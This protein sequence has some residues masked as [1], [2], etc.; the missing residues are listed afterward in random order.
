MFISIPGAG[1]TTARLRIKD[2]TA[3]TQQNQSREYASPVSRSR[4]YVY[5]DKPADG[6]VDDAL[7]STNSIPPNIRTHPFIRW[8]IITA[9]SS[10]SNVSTYSILEKTL[11]SNIQI[12]LKNPTIYIYY[13]FLSMSGDSLEKRLNDSFNSKNL[14]TLTTMQ[15]KPCC[16]VAF[17]SYNVFCLTSY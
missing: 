13:I 17:K 3:P 14:S 12:V 10:H 7:P 8:Y 5:G 9:T 6:D 2:D 16:Y 1:R 15:L 4:G 11:N